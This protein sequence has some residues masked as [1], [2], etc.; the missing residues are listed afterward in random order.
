M[1]DHHLPGWGDEKGDDEEKNAE[2]FEL[3]SEHLHL[4]AR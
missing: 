2:E 1:V 4:I 3:G